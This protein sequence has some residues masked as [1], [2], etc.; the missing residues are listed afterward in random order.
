MPQ[1][2]DSGNADKDC[3]LTT[4]ESLATSVK[5]G[6]WGERVIVLR[7]FDE[8][9]EKMESATLAMFA[10]RGSGDLLTE[11]EARKAKRLIARLRIPVAE[12]RGALYEIAKWMIEKRNGLATS[13]VAIPKIRRFRQ[14][15]DSSLN[16]VREGKKCLSVA[17]E[18]CT[19]ELVP[20]MN[21]DIPEFA[22]AFGAVEKLEKRLSRIRDCIAA[23]IP[24]KE[25]KTPKEQKL[26]QES[27]WEL[28]HELAA[29]MKPI[30]ALDYAVV[31]LI[32][33]ELTK[34]NRLDRVDIR[35]HLI[36]RFMARFFYVANNRDQDQAPPR[37]PSKGNVKLM[38][39]HLRT[40]EHQVPKWLSD[41]FPPPTG[42]K[43][44]KISRKN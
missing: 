12:L 19:A 32:E 42:Y 26:A 11:E 5:Q 22:R 27:A 39:S 2:T 16:R 10:P 30:R 4:A 43:T 33:R 44:S 7:P 40:G 1:T 17:S 24:P 15:C 29:L 20:L 8:F 28:T 31:Y 3:S 37:P 23:M 34:F 38:R 21:G 41:A 9:W 6:E 25:R 18:I 13:A 14:F 35:S 36:D